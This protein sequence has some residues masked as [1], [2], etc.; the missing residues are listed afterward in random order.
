MKGKRAGAEQRPDSIV[1][2]GAENPGFWNI[3]PP[4]TRPK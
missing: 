4:L 1:A 2:T 3:R